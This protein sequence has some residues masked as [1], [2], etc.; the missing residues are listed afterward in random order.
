MSQFTEEEKKKLAERKLVFSDAKLNLALDVGC[1][2]DRERGGFNVQFSD[3]RVLL[4][5]WMPIFL[6]AAEPI[7]YE[8]V[9]SVHQILKEKVVLPALKTI[10]KKYQSMLL[11]AVEKVLQPRALK[12]LTTFHQSARTT[13]NDV[14][15]WNMRRFCLTSN[16]HYLEQSSQLSSEE[17]TWLENKDDRAKLELTPLLKKA[18]E[19]RGFWKVQSKLLSDALQSQVMTLAE[20]ALD[21]LPEDLRN[22]DAVEEAQKVMKEPEHIA[23]ERNHLKE[24]LQGINKALGI[25]KPHVPPVRAAVLSSSVAAQAVAPV[26]AVTGAASGGRDTKR[27]RDGGQAQVQEAV[28]K[29]PR[30]DGEE[31]DDEGVGGGLGGP[32]P[33][34]SHP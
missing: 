26:V 25:G 2:L 13:V 30:T 21:S 10:S 34:P 7:L 23:K 8:F 9:D 3:N 11:P 24:R 4:K 29:K 6:E 33:S 31:G 5:A 14:L 1:V 18:G 12:V 28:G 16:E 17:L 19:V 20:R 32:S 27:V 15:S 22:V